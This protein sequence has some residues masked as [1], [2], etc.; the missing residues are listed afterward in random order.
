[1]SNKRGAVSRPQAPIATVPA[2]LALPR[3]ALVF[4]AS[5]AT[6]WQTM[7]SP[8]HFSVR[9]NTH[10]CV[11]YPQNVGIRHLVLKTWPSLPLSKLDFSSLSTSTFLIWQ[12]LL[13]TSYPLP[14]TT[15]SWPTLNVEKFEWGK[16]DEQKEDIHILRDASTTIVFKPVP[17]NKELILPFLSLSSLWIIRPLATVLKKGYS[18]CMFIYSSLF[19]FLAPIPAGDKKQRLN[20][21]QVFQALQLQA[22]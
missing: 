18:L 8:Q 6:P 13:H 7:K 1:M 21:F 16:P 19:L 9:S 3:W 10:P 5:E 12:Q 2:S 15:S 11:Y 17:L 20:I 4:R 14:L 22:K